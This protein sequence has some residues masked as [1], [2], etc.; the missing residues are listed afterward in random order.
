MGNRSIATIATEHSSSP[1]AFGKLSS[2]LDFFLPEHRYE[3]DSE[4]Q[5]KGRIII[6]FTVTM[7]LVCA[8]SLAFTQRSLT[9]PTMI[10]TAISMIFHVSC[11]LV[12]R[13]TGQLS[14]ATL[15]ISI[16]I[17]GG[18]FFSVYYSGGLASNIFYWNIYIIL[19]AMFLSGTR[20]AWVIVV[21]VFAELFVFYALDVTGY[22]L[23]TLPEVA[24]T[25][26][27]QMFGIAIYVFAGVFIGWMYDSSRHRAEVS[28]EK[29]AQERNEA[30][31]AQKAAELAS[32]A[33]SD[34]LATMS[35]E[36]RTPLNA[37]IGYSEMLLEEAPEMEPEEMEP[38]LEK[39][40]Q[41]GKHLLAL[42]NDILDFSKIE[43]GKMVLHPEVFSVGELMLE[44]EQTIQPLAQ[45]NENTFVVSCDNEEEKMC[46]DR[47]KVRQCLLNL[48][49]NANK[50]TQGGEVTLKA[51]N[52]VI[53]D[54]DCVEFRVLDTG[55][56]MTSEQ[57]ENLFEK[58]TQADSSTSRKYGGAGLGLAI[59]Q[60]LARLMG[61]DI[62]VESVED[63]GTTFTLQIPLKSGAA[64]EHK[65]SPT[66]PHPA[67]RSDSLTQL[68]QAASPTNRTVLVIDDDPTVLDM[69]TRFLTKE[70][71]LVVST[72]SG[73]EGLRIAEKLEPFA[74]TLDV[75]MPDM[76]GW[77]VLSELKKLP[78]LADT[79]VIMVTIV[80]DMQRGYA[81]GAAD[82]LTKPFE[83]ERIL[84]TLRKYQPTQKPWDV[85]IVED[86]DLSRDLLTSIMKK[87]GWDTREAING[88]KALEE[89]K[90]KQP[91]LILLDLM[92]P[93]MDGFEFLE[94]M[95][96]EEDTRTIPTIII[97]AK[98]ITQED[99]QRL[100]GYVD[101]LL[102]KAGFSKEDLL[103]EIRT[104]VRSQIDKEA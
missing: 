96:E 98:E 72:S 16:G 90:A 51:Y 32:H 97:T 38:D 48:L 29:L 22:K 49:S 10:V 52:T 79:P 8:M 44:I 71:F 14:L 80:D 28:K 84:K 95:R 57:V 70:G 46:T 89:V 23:P 33:K 55:I 74:I 20:S 19:L 69:M 83:R 27:Q 34:F 12:M 25:P 42:I 73:E 5:R 58:F 18:V 6:G 26:F 45:K 39:I 81:L 1:S 60:R 4:L 3:G 24:V 36:L 94:K 47:V 68:R 35:H 17:G 56:G 62:F 67:K 85:L 53:N 102:N 93:E 78:A 99:R 30:E 66:E 37:I 64:L 76:D 101:H 59:T 92:M 54:L 87:S 13:K 82:F 61:G 100:S 75:K 91:D 43:A 15:L 65:S 9:H 104:L 103:Q 77:A 88:I 21:L 50:F 11:L 86:D 41:A 7:F 63:E 40:C 2:A 31:A